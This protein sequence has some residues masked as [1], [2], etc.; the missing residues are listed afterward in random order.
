MIPTKPYKFIVALLSNLVAV[1]AGLAATVSDE[2]WL[3][4]ISL[5]GA[6]ANPVLVWLKNNPPTEPV[7]IESTG[8]RVGAA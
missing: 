4:W 1:L 8:T 6:L 2:K 5:V 7:I 3:Y